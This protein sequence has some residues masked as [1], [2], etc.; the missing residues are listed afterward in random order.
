MHSTTVA[1]GHGADSRDITRRTQRAALIILVEKGTTDLEYNFKQKKAQTT[2]QI[3]GTYLLPAQH[4]RRRRRPAHHGWVGLL[5]MTQ[6][7]NK[8]EGSKFKIAANM[9]VSLCV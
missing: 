3:N 5:Q 2:L 9:S 8:R 1:V 4:R 7:R 6:N